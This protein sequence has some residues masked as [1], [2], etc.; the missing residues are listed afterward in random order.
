MI[1]ESLPD[2]IEGMS[3]VL[4]SLALSPLVLF[5]AMIAALVVMGMMTL[6][7]LRKD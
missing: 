4:T 7:H 5:L 3:Q 2:T 6:S 1:N